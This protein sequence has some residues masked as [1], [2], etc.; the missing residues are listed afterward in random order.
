MKIIKWLIL[1]A[2]PLIV[3]SF[4][5]SYIRWSGGLGLLGV[6]VYFYIPTIILN[7]I[8]LFHLIRGLHKDIYMK[9]FYSSVLV[10]VYFL[11]FSH[12]LEAMF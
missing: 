3:V 7:G 8:L 11:V 10:V 6:F 12:L 5:V 9:I 1:I 2:Q 4:I